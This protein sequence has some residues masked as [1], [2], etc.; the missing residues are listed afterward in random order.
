MID[1]VPESVSHLLQHAATALVGAWLAKRWVRMK[2]VVRIDSDTFVLLGPVVNSYGLSKEAFDL[3]GDKT[4]EQVVYMTFEDETPASRRD[5]S[6][7]RP[8]SLLHRLLLEV[9]S[10]LSRQ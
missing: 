3:L 10:R 9:R 6:I 7:I 5:K 4:D 8:T 1:F 2:K